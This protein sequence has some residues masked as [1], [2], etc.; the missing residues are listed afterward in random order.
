V[1]GGGLL[2]H[3]AEEVPTLVRRST[4]TPPE[5]K[6]PYNCLPLDESVKYHIQEKYVLERQPKIYIILAATTPAYAAQPRAS[7]GFVLL[8]LNIDVIN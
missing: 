2:T 8:A 1:V 6:S 5:T 4:T 7:R 3:L